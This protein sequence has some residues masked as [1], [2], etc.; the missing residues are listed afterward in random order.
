LNIMMQGHLVPDISIKFPD[1]KPHFYSIIIDDKSRI[2]VRKNPV[3]RESGTNHEYD[4]FNK[5]GLYLY[6]INLDHYPYLIKDGYIYTRMTNEETGL[7]QIKR[8]RIKNWE[9][10]QEGIK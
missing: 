3:S 1:Y 4:V 9:K 10:I 5:E 2:Y 7:E 6:R 8:Y